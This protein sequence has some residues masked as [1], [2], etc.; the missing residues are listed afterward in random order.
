MYPDPGGPETYGF[1][2]SESVT[3]GT[4]KVCQREY[5]DF[6]YQI[7]SATAGIQE[8]SAPWQTSLTI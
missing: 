7:N 4:R 6:F 2:E 8:F 1:Y 3:L 5:V